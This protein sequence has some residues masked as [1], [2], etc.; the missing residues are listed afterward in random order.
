MVVDVIEALVTGAPVE[1]PL[2]IPNSG[3]CPDLPADVVVEAFC[4]VDANAIRGRDRVVAPPAL[5]ALLRRVAAAQEL[6]VDA[7]LSGSR[8]TLLAALFTDPLASALDHDR[9]ARLADAIVD[10]TA[11]WLPQFGASAP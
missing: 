4:T 10:S 2:N 5:G 11:A 9:L 7:A 3:Q 6:T 8:D 1:L